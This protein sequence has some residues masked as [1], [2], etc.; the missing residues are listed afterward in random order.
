MLA[1]APDLYVE[2]VDNEGRPVKEG[3]IGEICVSGGRNPYLPLL[4][5]RTGDF[6]RLAPDQQGR[7]RLYDLQAREPIAFV[8]G[9]GLPVCMVDVAR[10]IREWPLV[11]HEFSQQADRSCRLVIQPLAGYQV[12]VDMVREK[13][14]KLFG[15]AVPVTVE[16]DQHLGD[17]RPGGKVIPFRSLIP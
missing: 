8:D 5:Y 2:I 14:E 6:G 15:P 13:L 17:S 1:A 10:I 4:R 7:L 3:E 12:D 11:Q 16:L 9:D